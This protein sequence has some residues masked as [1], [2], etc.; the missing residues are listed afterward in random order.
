MI[1]EYLKFPLWLQIV[2]VPVT[3]I[4]VLFKILQVIPLVAIGYLNRW[5]TSRLE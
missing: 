2:L 3:W 4:A 5:L 1:K